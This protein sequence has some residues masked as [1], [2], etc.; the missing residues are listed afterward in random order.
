MEPTNALDRKGE[1]AGSLALFRG[2][3]RSAFTPSLLRKKNATHH[4]LRP[5]HRSVPVRVGME[6]LAS[7]AKAVRQRVKD[8]E[9][10]LHL[11]DP[12]FELE[13]GR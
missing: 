4:P 1:P 9:T 12:L 5:V 7:K 3:T 8:D 6:D 11:K 10:S 2:T 13:R